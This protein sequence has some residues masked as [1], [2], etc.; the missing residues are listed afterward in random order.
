MS[1]AVKLDVRTDLLRLIGFLDNHRDLDP[2]S[3]TIDSTGVKVMFPRECFEAFKAA[4]PGPAKLRRSEY[5]RSAWYVVTRGST[6]YECY[7]PVI[8]E[9][10]DVTL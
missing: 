6:T 3:V 10:E 7:T 4:F 2:Q 9:V 1:E 5:G 8:P